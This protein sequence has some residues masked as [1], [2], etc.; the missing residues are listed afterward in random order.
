MGNNTINI[1]KENSFLKTENK[2]L[3]SERD[4][5][6]RQLDELKRLVFGVKSERFTPVD[7]SQL[8]LFEQLIAEKEKELEK[9]TITYQR[10][11][12]TKKK[13]KPVRTV[14]PA[15]FPRIEEVIYPDNL[16]PSWKKIGEEV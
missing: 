16:D 12:E 3:Q 1:Q 6:K 13:E 11:K 7:N 14:I 5:F 9:H 4:E 15:H 8:E 2:N 10:D